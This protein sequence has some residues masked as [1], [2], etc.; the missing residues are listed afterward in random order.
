M[1]LRV[2]LPD[3][4]LP[5][6]RTDPSGCSRATRSILTFTAAD[7]GEEFIAVDEGKERRGRALSTRNAVLG[8]EL[9]ELKRLIEE[10]IWFGLGTFG[11]IGWSVAVPALVGLFAGI[12]L[13]RNVRAP[14]SWTLML[15]MGG[16]LLGCYNAWRWLYYESS[17]IEREEEEKD[18]DDG[19]A[20]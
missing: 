15:F 1:R 6:T 18:G 8:Q 4:I 13:D 17:V 5:K 11:V 19:K 9:G 10:S 14:F 7:G 12:W 16:L 3:Q 2:L 20:A